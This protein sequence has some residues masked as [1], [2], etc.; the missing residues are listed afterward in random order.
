MTALVKI[1]MKVRKRMAVWLGMKTVWMTLPDM[2]EQTKIMMD[3][4][5]DVVKSG[6]SVS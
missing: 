3:L 2:Q 1:V 4:V 5:D 6:Q